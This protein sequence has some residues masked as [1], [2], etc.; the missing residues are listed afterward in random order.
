[1]KKQN[2]NYNEVIEFAGEC[3]YRALNPE[4]KMTVPNMVYI[5]VEKKLDAFETLAE[6]N[7]KWRNEHP[8]TEVKGETTSS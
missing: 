6:R 2:Y 8:E 3:V 4:S 7:E 5:A 1:M